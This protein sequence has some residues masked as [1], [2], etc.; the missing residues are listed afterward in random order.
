MNVARAL[1]IRRFCLGLLPLVILLSGCSMFVMAGKM[2]KG[3]P[4]QPGQ[5]HQLT[6]TDLAKGKQRVVVVCSVPAA[7]EED[8]SSLNVDLIEGVTRQ[9]RLHGIDVVK[10]D[11]VARWIDDH[12]G[13]V[14]DPDAIAKAFDVD[15]IAWVDL[16]AFTIREENSAN[17]LRGQAQGYIHAYKVEKVDNKRYALSAYTTEFTS[18]YPPL[19]PIS[20]IGRSPVLFQKE[21]IDRVS[22]QLAEL[23][24]DHPLGSDI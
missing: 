15:Y 2:L 10:P 20:D 11:E 8:L 24:Y 1:P 21:F 7:V 18:A 6:C 14:S 5:F 9:M 16:Q 22:R 3:D 12:G 19:Q 13:V 4:K 23:F 17:L